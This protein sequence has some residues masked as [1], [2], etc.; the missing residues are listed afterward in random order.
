MNCAC[1]SFEIKIFELSFVINYNKT[2]NALE[3]MHT[4][5]QKN[6]YNFLISRNYFIDNLCFTIFFTHRKSL[7]E[8]LE[9]G[10][11]L[12]INKRH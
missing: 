1:F 2:N 9:N 11:K 8:Y 4:V 12:Y 3:D 10:Y 5:S 7:Y 6:V